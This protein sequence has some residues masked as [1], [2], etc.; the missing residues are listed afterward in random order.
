M[1]LGDHNNKTPDSLISLYSAAPTPLI[2]RWV[3][4]FTW[5]VLKVVIY[6]VETFS[7]S[8]ALIQQ[9]SP[10]I[11]RWIS[12]I[13]IWDTSLAIPLCTT[14]WCGE[15]LWNWLN[16]K[17]NADCMTPIG[18]KWYCIRIGKHGWLVR[19]MFSVSCLLLHVAARRRELH[20]TAGAV[21]W[22]QPDDWTEFTSMF[23]CQKHTWYQISQYPKTKVWNFTTP[24]KKLTKGSKETRDEIP[25]RTKAP[26]LVL[27]TSK[28]SRQTKSQSMPVC[29]VLSGS[30][31]QF[32]RAWSKWKNF[33]RPCWSKR[34]PTASEASV[35]SSGSDSALIC[36]PSR[37]HRRCRGNTQRPTR[38]ASFTCSFSPNR[39]HGT[40]AIVDTR[41]FQSL[42][43]LRRR[44]QQT[45]TF[46]SEP[47][48]SIWES[49][50][51]RGAEEFQ[52]FV[53]QR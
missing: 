49:E 7:W 48:S 2:S 25:E 10:E 27:P 19:Q 51:L 31:R 16:S 44:Q 52:K 37:L 47:C 13:G 35:P 33:S 3:A 15:F 30:G 14:R 18:R 12:S 21:V 41:L 40:T 26:V 22:Q 32:V 11:N 20:T 5:I 45:P 29:W 6:L 46:H 36:S 1:H 17:L 4:E 28:T 50:S 24:I 34:T 9:S 39:L 43:L 53:L 42:S 8:C 38:A 23:P